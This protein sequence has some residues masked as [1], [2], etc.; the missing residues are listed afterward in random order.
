VLA[1]DLK[2]AAPGQQ[3]TRDPYETLSDGELKKNLAEVMQKIKE[4]KS[5]FPYSLK[6][7][8]LDRPWV[9]AKVKSIGK[10]IDDELKLREMCQATLKEVKKAL[11]K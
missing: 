7:Q 2:E 8:L 6:D 1:A 10:K 9:E 3:K 5:T 4:L 11:E